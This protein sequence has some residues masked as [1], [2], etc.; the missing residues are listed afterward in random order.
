MHITAKYLAVPAIAGT[1]L[2]VGTLAASAH[3]MGPEAKASSGTVASVSGNTVTINLNDATG[4][5]VGDAISVID[6]VIA[7]ANRPVVGTV[8]TVSS[9]SFTVQ[10]KN[11][12]TATVNTSA[13]TTIKKDGQ[14][15]SLSDI[16]SGAFVAVRGAFDSATNTIAAGS[17]NIFTQAKAGLHL[18][19]FGHH[20]PE[21][22][23]SPT[24][25][26]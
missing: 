26:P 17:V 3:M 2:G 9:G 21:E 5:K 23:P 24:P 16:V 20:G 1:L 12:N 13:S 11:G 7:A 8:G 10:E 4:I 25:T 18:G 22:T 15:A 19:W 6:H 14:T